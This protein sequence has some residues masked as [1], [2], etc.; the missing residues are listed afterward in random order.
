MFKIPC[1]EGASSLSYVL[2]IAV[3][4]VPLIDSALV[5]FSR[6]SGGLVFS[7]VG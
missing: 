1:E 7:A 4:E 3:R 5:K 6:R 2:H